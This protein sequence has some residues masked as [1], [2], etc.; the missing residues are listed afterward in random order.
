MYRSLFRP[1]LIA[2][3][4]SL[5]AA[6]AQADDVLYVQK[7]T[8]LNARNGP[9]KQYAADHVLQPGTRV[10]VLQRQGD[11]TQVR[12]PDGTQAWVFGSYLGDQAPQSDPQAE[13][14][15]NTKAQDPGQRQDQRPE[16]G[17][18]NDQGSDQAND[19]RPG[20]RSDQRADARGPGKSR[21]GPQGQSGQRP[22]RDRSQQHQFPV[23]DR[24]RQVVSQQWAQQSSEPQ[25]TASQSQP[26]TSQKADQ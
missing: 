10:S 23:Q 19:Q 3:A 22:Q 13:A 16:Q 21:Q 24:P 15:A 12:T 14:S 26:I 5:V 4:L 1:L 25:W 18:F 11:W 9:G 20:Q 2:S 8:Y 6:T 7:D 17:Q